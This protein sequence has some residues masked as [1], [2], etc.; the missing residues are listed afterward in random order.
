MLKVLLGSFFDKEE[1]PDLRSRIHSCLSKSAVSNPRCTTEEYDE[2]V[3]LAATDMTNGYGTIIPPPVERPEVIFEVDT[4][5]FTPWLRRGLYLVVALAAAVVAAVI[6]PD[7]VKFWVRPENTKATAPELA[8]GTSTSSASSPENGESLATATT[9]DPILE[10]MVV[11]P[12]REPK[13]SIA[14]QFEPSESSISLP[15]PSSASIAIADVESMDN[16][17]I[18]GVI[19]SQ[20]NFL[21]DRVGLTTTQN[22]QVDVW[23]DRAANAIVGRP[24]T[25]AEKQVFHSNKSENRI[26]KYVDSLISSNEFSRFWSLRLAEHYLGRKLPPTRDLSGAEYA[27]LEW[28]QDSL[29]QKIFIGDIEQQLIDGPSVA[30]YASSR[31]DPASLWLIEVMEKTYNNHRETFDQLVPPVKRRQPREE[32]LIGVSRQLMRI[33]GNPAMVCSQCHV[34]E[35]AN[36]D[37]RNYVSMPKQ[38]FAVG[39]SSFWSVPANFSGLTIV[40]QTF[41]RTLKTE[42]PVGFYYEDGEGRM[43]LATMG[44]P[45]L[46]KSDLANKSLGEWFRTSSEPRRAI[47]ELAWGYIFKQPLVPAIGLSEGEGLT[48]RDDLRELLANQMQLRKADLGTLVSWIVFTKSFRLE[49]M[50]TDTPWYIKS[51]E[52]QIAES[53]RRMRLFGGFSGYQSAVSESG[54]LSPSKVATW[55]D[56]KRAFQKAE[57]ATLAQA[58]KDHK[59]KVAPNSSKVEYSEDQVRFFISVEQPYSHLKALSQRWANSAMSWQMLLEHAYLATDARF[60]T[61]VE[62]DEANKLFESSGRDRAKALVVIAN[63]RLGSW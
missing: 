7:S 38:Q 59:P 35:A 27:F 56:Q 42:P 1:A 32:S 11:S 37:M 15:R 3:Q 50:K 53:Q 57:T 49:G 52:P 63:G 39:D 43:K 6:L 61:K 26:A 33:A 51:T 8:S 34:D 18:V 62:R 40:H 60:P 21:W 19:D 31:S 16:K 54:K 9:S 55:L 45:T 29:T 2:A 30:D 36:S 47:V 44:P 46:R 4:D 12:S 48:E 23:L 10:N 58:G 20:L 13:E 14:A 24:A 41:E 22:I 17:E 28:L 5:E 25:N